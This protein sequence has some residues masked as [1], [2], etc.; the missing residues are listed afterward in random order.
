MAASAA[1]RRLISS[2][3]PGRVPNGVALNGRKSGC[4]AM[5]CRMKSQKD[6][7]LPPLQGGVFNANSPEVKTRGLV[8]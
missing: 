3:I 5:G 4:Y 1:S 7:F 2:L 8:L 6:L